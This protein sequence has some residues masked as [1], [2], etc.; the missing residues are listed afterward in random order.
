MNP[1]KTLNN[2][3]ISN[4]NDSILSYKQ[5]YSTSKTTHPKLY[6]LQTSPSQLQ[7]PNNLIN[8]IKKITRST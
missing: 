6:L 8:H 1:P 5:T 3:N 7:T 4:K 2:S